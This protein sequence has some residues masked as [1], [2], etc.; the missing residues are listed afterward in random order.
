MVMWLEMCKPHYHVVSLVASSA[1][2]RI[3]MSDVPTSSDSPQV[4]SQC[5][6]L[7]YHIAII[8]GEKE[9]EEVYE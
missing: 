1:A 3:A 2:E 8:L 7:A 9:T 4:K 5:C 6:I